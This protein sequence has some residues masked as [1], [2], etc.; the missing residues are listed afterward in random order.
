LAEAQAVFSHHL[1][2]NRFHH[3]RM[4]DSEPERKRQAE[5]HKKREEEER[6]QQED[7]TKKAW[8]KVYG[9][10][11][12]FWDHARLKEQYQSV[13]FGGN[14]PTPLLPSTYPPGT[15]LEY[16]P[17]PSI[18]PTTSTHHQ[19]VP[20]GNYSG[21]LIQLVAMGGSGWRR[22]DTKRVVTTVR[23]LSPLTPH[24]Q[25]SLLTI[26]HLCIAL[27]LRIWVI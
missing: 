3:E 14:Y 19:T 20:D 17:T 13:D 2:T 7:D 21:N 22:E 10:S 9:D 23:S 5:E 4:V 1:Q 16:Y 6:K 15:G 26:P 12:K 25:K 8:D 24:H 27:E 11:E 18:G